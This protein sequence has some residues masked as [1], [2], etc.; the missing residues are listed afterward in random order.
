MKQKNYGTMLVDVKCCDVAAIK[1]IGR[2]YGIHL[3]SG[4]TP[5]TSDLLLVAEPIWYMK[6]FFQDRSEE[7]RLIE[8]MNE[9]R[10]NGI[11]SSVLDVFGAPYERIRMDADG[12]VT[13]MCAIWAEAD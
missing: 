1:R 7:D 6:E 9:C 4:Q 12:T 2:Q 13:R 10:K 3:V 5:G 11:V 8:F